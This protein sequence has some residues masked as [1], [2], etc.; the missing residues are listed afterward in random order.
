MP[1]SSY[2][3]IKTSKSECG[4]IWSVSI[5]RPKKMNA[6]SFEAMQEIEQFI[7]K[8]VN[9]LTSGA[10]VVIFSGEGKHFTS[11]LDLSSAA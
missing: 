4:F 9:P 5:N 11:G 1:S 2:E 7:L 10:R 3:F 6:V 8:E